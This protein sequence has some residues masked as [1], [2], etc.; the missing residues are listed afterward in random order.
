MNSRHKKQLDQAQ[1]TAQDK[2]VEE[3]FLQEI[4]LKHQ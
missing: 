3:P 2:T 4:M 1:W